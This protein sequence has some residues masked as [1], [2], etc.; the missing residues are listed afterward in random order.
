MQK[1]VSGLHKFQSEI[2]RSNKDLFDRLARGQNPDAMFIGC[3]DSRVDPSM[4]TQTGPGDLFVLRNAGNIVPPFSAS[5]C[6][7]AATIEFAVTALGVKDIV[8]CGHTLCGA[9]RG[10]LDESL[11]AAMPAVK[12]WLQNAEAT[13]RIIR[14]NYQHLEGPALLTAAVEENVLVQLENLRTHPS[15]W[16]KLARGELTLHGWVYKIETGEFFEYD[17]E[18]AQ[19]VPFGEAGMS[20][21]PSST[22]TPRKTG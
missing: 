19:F 18:R 11:V 13:R 14:E 8:V 10:L 22:L 6:G 16:A 17:G 12:E 1:L 15:V 2:F 5:R 3:S 7:E 20:G 9:M 21:E 4:I